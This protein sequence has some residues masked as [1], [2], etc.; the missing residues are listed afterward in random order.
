[1]KYLR[2]NATSPQGESISIQS[3]QLMADRSHMV[4]ESQFLE[5]VKCGDWSRLHIQVWKREQPSSPPVLDDGL[6][7]G[8]PHQIRGT[9]WSSLLNR[10]VIVRTANLVLRAVLALRKA[11]V[12][13]DVSLLTGFTTLAR[14][15]VATR[16]SQ[17]TSMLP[18]CRS[19]VLQHEPSTRR[20]TARTGHFDATS[21]GSEI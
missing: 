11:F 20:T 6:G 18:I 10:Y 13:S 4:N 2:R 14:L 12:A 19:K 1:M 21:K 3:T 15:G 5:A 8:C 9:V 16:K 7:L 17:R